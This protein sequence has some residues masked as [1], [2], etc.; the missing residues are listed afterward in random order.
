[1]WGTPEI[2]A[3]AEP[4]TPGPVIALLI[5][6][7]AMANTN[8]QGRMDPA[9]ETISRRAS[10]AGSR[11]TLIVPMIAGNCVQRDPKEERGVSWNQTH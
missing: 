8:M 2:G 3:P 1:M 11:S 7:S 5:I 4:K 6:G 10:G 9:G